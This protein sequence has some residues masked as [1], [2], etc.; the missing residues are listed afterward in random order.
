[1]QQFVSTKQEN[2]LALYVSHE[3]IDSLYKLLFI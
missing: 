2:F 3:L 1:M